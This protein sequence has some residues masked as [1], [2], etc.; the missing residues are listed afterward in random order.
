MNHKSNV[1]SKNS[2]YNKLYYV[3]THDCVHWK[4]IRDIC[5]VRLKMQFIN[6]KGKCKKARNMVEQERHPNFSVLC[7]SD[8]YVG[9]I[10]NNG[11]KWVLAPPWITHLSS[12][13]WKHFERFLSKCIYFWYVEVK[14]YPIWAMLVH[15]VYYLCIYQSVRHAVKQNDAEQFEKKKLYQQINIK[16]EWKRGHK[17][18]DKR[19]M[20]QSLWCCLCSVHLVIFIYGFS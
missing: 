2:C 6:Q 16:I 12:F 18:F 13:N 5:F 9:W 4:S 11:S 20:F 17:T 7:A 19:L 3:S 8:V 10:L 1:N 15:N 14:I